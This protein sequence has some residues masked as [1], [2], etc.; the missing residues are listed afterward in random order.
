MEYIIGVAGLALIAAGWAA[1]LSNALKKGKPRVPLPFAAL[2]CAGSALLAAY[3]ILQSDAIFIVLNAASA[4][5]ALANIALHMKK[6][7]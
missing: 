1:E 4:A 2:Y 6:R 5:I 3:S 7:E